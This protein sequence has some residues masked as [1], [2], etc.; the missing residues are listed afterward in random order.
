MGGGALFCSGKSA[1]SG[2]TRDYSL[3]L[4]QDWEGEVVQVEFEE[5]AWRREVCKWR[6]LF[7]LEWIGHPN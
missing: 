5:S 3:F 2:R 6:K 7:Q 4:R 1:V